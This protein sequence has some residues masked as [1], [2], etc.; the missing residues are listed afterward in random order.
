MATRKII[1]KL[2]KKITKPKNLLKAMTV[3]GIGASLAE[4]ANLEKFAAG[5]QNLLRTEVVSSEIELKVK[6]L[7]LLAIFADS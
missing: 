3:I 6:H 4:V 1:I 5:H 2:L 7:L